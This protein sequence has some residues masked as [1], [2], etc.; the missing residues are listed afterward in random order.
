MNDST[1]LVDRLH[2]LAVWYRTGGTSSRPATLLDEAAA[3]IAELEAQV[4]H[5]R[6]WLGDAALRHAV[7][8]ERETCKK[9][10]RGFASA[11]A[12]A[13]GQPIGPLVDR[14]AAAIDERPAP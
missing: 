3:R 11:E 8:A 13:H 12:R 5:Q 10:I 2:Q 14:I 4:N 6:V 9:I 1:T 7:L